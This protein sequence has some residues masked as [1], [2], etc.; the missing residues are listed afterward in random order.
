MFIKGDNVL[1]T[2]SHSRSITPTNSP[3]MHTFSSSDQEDE[4]DALEYI[5]VNL[6]ERML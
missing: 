4:Y 6:T 3:R 5:W 1:L 2:E